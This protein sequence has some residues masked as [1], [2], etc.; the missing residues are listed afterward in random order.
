[1]S[2][3]PAATR[4]Q[5]P[6]QEMLYRLLRDELAGPHAGVVE[7]HVGACPD[8]Q[9]ALQHLIGGMPGTVV[10]PDGPARRAEPPPVPGHE[11]LGVLGEGG[12]GV[13]YKAVQTAVGRVVAL[14]MIRGGSGSANQRA[15]FR[16]EAEAAAKLTHPGIAR[17]YEFGE[18]AGALYFT[19]EFCDGGSLANKLDGTPWHPA[20]AARL[21]EM[22]A[23]AVAAAHKLGIVHRDLKPGNILLASPH[24]SDGGTVTD[25]SARTFR[26]AALRAPHGAVPKVAD[27]G[28]SKRL[29]SPDG[30]TAT[31]AV[32]GTPSYMSPEQASGES[33]RVGP[34]ADVYALGAVLYELLTGRPPFKAQGVL[35]TLDLVRHQEPVAVRDLNPACPR[36]LETICLKCLQKAPEKRYAGAAELADDLRRFQEHRLIVARPVGR[37]EQFAKWVKR[38]KGLSAGLA[39][40]VIVLVAGSIVSTVFGL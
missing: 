28:I 10:A 40:A 16:A 38:N 20:A 32:V 29:D 31:G 36:D 1:M 3:D 7:E 27:F 33:K 6:D 26:Y 37:A 30:P 15:R 23:D 4:T 9:R 11:I 12:M 17:V 18:C 39:A 24:G 35:E 5:C 2:N 21:A 13:V 25:P 19:L 14:K 8:C 34:P 22:L